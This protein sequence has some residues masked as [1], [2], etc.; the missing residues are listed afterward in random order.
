LNLLSL[1]N[2]LDLL[3]L[4]RNRNLTVNRNVNRLRDPP[5]GSDRQVHGAM[6]TGGALS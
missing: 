4:N 3:G 2:H 5:V 6:P 1:L